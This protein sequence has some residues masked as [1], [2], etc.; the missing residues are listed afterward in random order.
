MNMK[1]CLP[2]PTRQQQVPPTSLLQTQTS[3]QE[4]SQSL[5]LPVQAVNDVRTGLD[6]RC[7]EHVRQEGE[8]WVERLEGNF[9]FGGEG[10]G[11]GCGGGEG[12]VADSGHQVCK[13]GQVQDEGSGQEGVL[14]SRLPYQLNPVISHR[15]HGTYLANV[16]NTQNVPPAHQQLRI[17]LVHSPLVITYARSVLDNDQVIG[18]F[19]LLVHLASLGV[20]ASSGLVEKIVGSNH[21]IHNRGLGNFL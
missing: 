11:C 2:S 21:V 19:T 20:D 8:N 1:E 5:S 18:V 6:E 12:T 15:L 10:V 9:G 3:L 13:D 4:R 17:V 14:S 7:L 16:E